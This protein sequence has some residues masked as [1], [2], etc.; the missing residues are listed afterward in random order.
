MERSRRTIRAFAL[1]LAAL[2]VPLCGA[3]AAALPAGVTQGPT[4]AGITEYRLPNGLQV[5]LTPDAS[6]DTITINITY[7]V[8]SRHE[9]YGERGMAHLLEHMLFKGTPR[10]PNV[11]GEFLKRGVRYNGTTSFDRTNYFGTFPASE[12]NLAAMLALEADRMVNSRVSK[13]DLESEMTVVRNEFESGENSPFGLLRDRMIGTAYHWHNYGRSVIGTRSDIENVPIERLQAFYRRYYQPDN[14]TLVIAGRF[15]PQKA[16]ALVVDAFGAIPRPSR[17]LVNTYTVEPPQDG[18]RQVV[19]RRVGDVQLVSAMY[20]APPG[21]HP[22]FAAV[23]LLTLALTQQPSG[24]LHKALVES[25]KATATFG[26]DRQT[27]EAGSVYFGAALGKDQSLDAARDALLGV[28]EGFADQPITD[29]EVERARLKIQNDIENLLSDSRALAI[30]LSEFVAMGDWRLL[31]WFR[32]RVAQVTR[33]E[34]QRAAVTYLRP[35]NRTLGIFVPRDQPERVAIPA[36]PDVTAMLKDFADTAG[37]AAGEA[38]DP[39]PGNLEARL[40]RRELPGGMKLAMLPKRTRGGKVNAAL[41]LHWGDE[42]STTGRS[43]ACSIASA[44]LA[45]GTRHHSRAELRD[46]LDR[47]RANVSVGTDGATIDTVRENLAEALKLTAEML[48]EP[49]FPESEFEQ[50]KHSLLTSI[51]GQRSD[52]SAL[53]GLTIN[54]HLAPYPP[55]HWHYTPTL[56]ERAAQIR[57]VTLDDVRRCHADFLGATHSELAVVGDFDPG[58]IAPLV[59]RLFGEWKTPSPYARIPARYFDAPP[60]DRVIETPDKANAIYRAGLNL[61]LRDDDPEFAALVLGNYLLGGSSDSRLWRRIRETDGLSYSVG[62]W[63]TAGSHDAVGE[64]G[65][66]AIYAPQNRAKLEQAVREEIRRALDEGFAAEEV[67][68]AKKG[69]LK[70]RHLAR[71]SDAALA[72][73][74]CRYLEL[75]RTF[76]WDIEFEARIAALTPA[77]IRDALRRRLDVG[78]LTEVKAGDFTRLAGT[79][80]DQPSN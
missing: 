11:K 59:A 51:D 13:A 76:A 3:A 65:I 8:G 12:D 23:E 37:V 66:T 57:A 39:T 70:R 25:G 9:D 28:L 26:N 47:L 61:R 16:L 79:P 35:A 22:E 29:A 48:R 46:A 2:L 64:F 32:D 42:Q 50:I 78:N 5:L 68:N 74:L 44:M 27:R 55:G 52:P 1:L 4:V 41:V 43:T 20:H 19:L 21:T 7:L 73:R 63:L 36:A 60:I 31:F 71:N 15:E 45:R 6:Q 53:A 49:S 56:D 10:H 77:G 58:E 14:A 17:R 40:V 67:E 72:A 54:R 75:G 62:S 18:E 38:F 30:T 33:E 24:R 69:L 80:R 34:V